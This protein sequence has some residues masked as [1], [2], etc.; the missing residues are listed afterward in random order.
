MH[1]KCQVS[2]AGLAAPEGFNDA[3]KHISIHTWGERAQC[4]SEVQWS[5]AQRMAGE[6]AAAMTLM[7]A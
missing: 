4:A 1:C 7:Q 6:V 2:I 5:A 3:V